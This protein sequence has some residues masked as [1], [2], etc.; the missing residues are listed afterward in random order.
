MGRMSQMNDRMLE[1][2]ATNKHSQEMKANQ[3]KREKE[4]KAPTTSDCRSA[5]GLAEGSYCSNS[6]NCRAEHS[7]VTEKT[8]KTKET[9]ITVS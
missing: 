6:S 5:K 7:P 2:K 3:E 4:V 1:L 9:G 8:R